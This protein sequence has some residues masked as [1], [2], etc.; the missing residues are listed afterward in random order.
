M[1]AKCLLT[2]YLSLQTMLN[3]GKLFIPEQKPVT[4]KAIS[5]I[6]V[7]IIFLQKNTL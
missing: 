1:G 3:F 2:V 5:G 4:V 7:N 6:K